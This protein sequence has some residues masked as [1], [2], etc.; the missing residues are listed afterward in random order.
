MRRATWPT[1]SPAEVD[2]I[3]DR[4]LPARFQRRLAFQPLPRGLQLRFAAFE[5]DPADGL[6]SSGPPGDPRPAA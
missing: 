2:P 3:D 6:E 5:P 1:A 4:C